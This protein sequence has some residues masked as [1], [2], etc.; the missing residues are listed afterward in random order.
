MTRKLEDA[1]RTKYLE[2]KGL[3]VI[4][5]TNLDVLQNLEGVISEIGSA[6]RR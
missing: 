4:R 1:K 5:F 3:T 2:S 6:I